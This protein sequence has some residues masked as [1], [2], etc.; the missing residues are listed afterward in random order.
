MIVF[1][2]N[3]SSYDKLLVIS[4]NLSFHKVFSCSEISELVNFQCI[5]VYVI[6]NYDLRVKLNYALFPLCHGNLP[7]V[8]LRLH[9]MYFHNYIKLAAVLRTLSLR[10]RHPRL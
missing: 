8:K 9:R 1:D 7:S 4:V 10:Y 2:P 6:V 3:L 5:S